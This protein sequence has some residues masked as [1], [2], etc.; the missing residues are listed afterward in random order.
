MPLTRFKFEGFDFMVDNAYLKH[1]LLIAISGAHSYGWA[2]PKSDLDIR[3]VWVPDLAQAV[4]PFFPGKP[5]SWSE[6]FE[7]KSIDFA[8]YPLNHYLRLLCKGNVNAVENLFEPHLFSDAKLVET[9]QKIVLSHQH[10]GAVASYLGYAESLFKDMV[11][12]TR[13]AKYSLTKLLL[14]AYRVLLGGLCYCQNKILFSLQKQSKVLQ[15]EHCLSLLELY[16]KDS[17]PPQDLVSQAK[18]ELASLKQSLTQAK[19]S[20]PTAELGDPMIEL[21]HWAAGLYQAL[22]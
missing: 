21:D 4:S 14:Q 12:P 3:M 2:T 10:Q 16:L 6:T 13:L 8:E 17:V 19:Q 11:N 18:L 22:S 5:K 15:T 20:L 7:D 9:L 1:C